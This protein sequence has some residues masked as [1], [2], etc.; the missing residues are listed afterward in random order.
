MAHGLRTN[1]RYLLPGPWAF[2]AHVQNLRAHV[3]GRLTWVTVP[4][5]SSQRVAEANNDAGLQ[6]IIN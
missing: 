1:Q 5:E 3:D 2:P 4:S 6:V